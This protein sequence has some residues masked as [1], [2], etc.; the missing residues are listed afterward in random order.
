MDLARQTKYYW[1]KWTRGRRV[2]YN[3]PMVWNN[4]SS[5]ANNPVGTITAVGYQGGT[6]F[7]IHWDEGGRT[8][9]CDAYGTDKLW[10][11]PLEK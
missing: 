3:Q 2:R 4:F 11:L 5:D 10:L 1:S 7:R 6:K 9:S 8:M